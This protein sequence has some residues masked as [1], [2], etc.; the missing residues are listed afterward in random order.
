MPAYKLEEVHDL[1]A[2]ALK[3]G[4]VDAVISLYEPEAVLCPQ[5]GQVLVGRGK[6]IEYE[7]KPTLVMRLQGGGTW[8]VVIDNPGAE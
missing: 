3:A 6:T 2:Q 8:Q 4:D 1:F 5:P 7:L